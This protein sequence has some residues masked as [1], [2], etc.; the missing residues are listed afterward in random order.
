M[1]ITLINP[2][3]IDRRYNFT[4]SVNLPLG[5]SYIASYLLKKGYKVDVIDA[6]GEGL[7]QRTD[8]KKDYFLMGLTNSDIISKIDKKSGLIALSVRYSTQHNIVIKLIQDIKSKFTNIPIAVGGVHASFHPKLFL[9]AG[10]DYV[11]FG[12]GEISL[13]NLCSY[14]EHKIKKDQ[15]PGIINKCGELNNTRA[16]LIKDIDSLP[17]PA[18]ELFPLDNYSKEKSAQGPTNN[19]STPIISS[20]GC[21]N[22]CTFCASTVFWQRIWR[23]RS[24]KN[25][26]DEIEECIKKFDI[27]EFHFVDDNLTLD[28]K[29]MI[30]ICNEILRRDIKITWTAPTGIRPENMDFN[31]LSLMKKSGCVHITLAPESGSQNVLKEIFNKKLD[32]N[33]ILEIIENCNKLDITTAGF[34]IIGVIGETKKDKALTRRYVKSLAKKGLDEIGVFPLIPYPE[35]PISKKYSHIKEIKNFEELITGIIPRWYPKYKLVKKYKKKLY[36]SFFIYQT[37]YH[38]LKILRLINNFFTG[39]QDI[40]SDRVIKNLIRIFITKLI[41]RKNKTG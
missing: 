27:I 28:K 32:L 16:P 34:I 10:A 23:P 11:I 22:D 31:L 26:V 19:R 20:R 30:D 24:P 29:R 5:L 35:C 1:K 8:Y 7:N 15:L 33:K 13:Y 39:R 2:P 12:E 17:F 9:D 37:I 6:V 18:R 14:L 36:L 40:K 41:P 3:I 4:F 38:P 21:P 25:I